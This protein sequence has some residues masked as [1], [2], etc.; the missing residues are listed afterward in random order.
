M[1]LQRGFQP[2]GHLV[3]RSA[4]RLKFIVGLIAD[5]CVE[6]AVPDPLHTGDERVQRRLNMPEQVFCQ[7]E[8]CKRNA[9]AARSARIT[10]PP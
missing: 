2:R 7:I 3:D 9:T 6:I 10:V 4:G 8:I 5:G 1:R